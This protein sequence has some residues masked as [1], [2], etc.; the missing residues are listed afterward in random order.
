MDKP[1]NIFISYAHKDL[2]ENIASKKYDWL[3]D[4]LSIKKSIPLKEWSDKGLK[5]GDHQDQEIQKAI[6]NSNAAIL[7]IGKHFKASKYIKETE[8][9]LILKKEIRLIPIIIDKKTIN[10]YEVSYTNNEGV[11]I[12]KNLRH[13][14]SPNFNNP[15]SEITKIE[16]LDVILRLKTE[17]CNLTSINPKADYLPTANISNEFFTGRDEIFFQM[18]HSFLNEQRV[19]T[20][21]GLGGVGKTTIAKEFST[22]FELNYEKIIFLSATTPVIFSQEIINLAKNL[23]LIES[24]IIANT[25]DFVKNWIETETSWLMIIDNA[26]TEDALKAV[27]EF[28]PK[29]HKGNIIITTRM[30]NC[31]K[32]GFFH[33]IPIPEFTVENSQIFLEKRTN[34]K[35]DTFSL[36]L[37]QKLGYI[38]LAHE[39]AASFISEHNISYEEYLNS[40]NKE[41]FNQ[42]IEL[43]NQKKVYSPFVEERQKTIYLAWNI[44][45]EAVKKESIF[46]LEIFKLCSLLSPEPIPIQLVLQGITRLSEWKHGTI[47]S[48]SELIQKLHPL[49]KYS[50]IKN[51]NSFI[52]INPL[53]Q[54]VV[55]SSF[56]KEET[57]DYLNQLIQS[58][59]L[60]LPALD[61]SNYYEPLLWNEFLPHI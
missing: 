52:T 9:P 51:E 2:E 22:K 55:K 4:L 35:R 56:S 44:N 15:L 19:I 58:F 1:F 57:I 10:D 60:I 23:N 46:A 38:P 39:L 47:P 25:E 21:N 59:L 14:V 36:E 50:L 27:Q 49:K 32:F 42:K 29:K 8:L 40:F 20:L 48:E 12:K 43:L 34:R 24:E 26:D 45:F 5:I 31:Q 6:D 3:S 54:E 17:L 61:S 16:Q 30:E 33:K 13:L 7:F 28:L 11:E 18:N 53:V 37:S 41:L